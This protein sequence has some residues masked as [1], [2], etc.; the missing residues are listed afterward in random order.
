M[1]VVRREYPKLEIGVT[2]TGFPKC[3]YVGLRTGKFPLF[4][5]V[6]D[7]EIESGAFF[8]TSR[9]LRF[10][11]VD[12][13][14]FWILAVN[15]RAVSEKPFDRAREIFLFGV[16][17]ED[18]T[19]FLDCCLDRGTGE[20]LRHFSWGRFEVDAMFKEIQMHVEKFEDKRKKTR[21][22]QRTRGVLR[23]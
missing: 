10:E 3:I 15:Q 5:G 11:R 21:K 17:L 19:V 12:L 22:E 9:E 18:G 2:Q 14:G 4:D 1:A 16:D 7:V 13:F 8:R 20:A 23:K 6:L